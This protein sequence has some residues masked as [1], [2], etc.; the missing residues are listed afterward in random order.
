MLSYGCLRYT[1][2]HP[3]R[4]LLFLQVHPGIRRLVEMGFPEDSCRQVSTPSTAIWL[5]LF[6]ICVDETHLT[7]D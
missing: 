4:Q 3:Y 1:N 7:C 6:D 2:P 5:I